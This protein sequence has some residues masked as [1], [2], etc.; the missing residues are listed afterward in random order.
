MNFCFVLK[1]EK[2]KKREKVVV[3]GFSSPHKISI[4]SFFVKVPVQKI[5]FKSASLSPD[6]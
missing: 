4:S 2:K 5:V 3:V 1:G 6:A